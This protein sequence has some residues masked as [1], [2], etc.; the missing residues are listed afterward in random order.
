MVDVRSVSLHDKLIG[1]MTHIYLHFS[2]QGVVHNE[3]MAHPDPCRLHP[4]FGGPVSYVR[5]PRQVP[6]TGD[7]GHNESS[8]SRCH[9]SSTGQIDDLAG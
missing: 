1:H 9:R 8:Q 4:E 2:V 5:S 3:G 7:L 6:L